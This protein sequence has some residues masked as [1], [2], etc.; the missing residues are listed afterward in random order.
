[1]FAVFDGILVTF[2][3]AG[4]GVLV[5]NVLVPKHGGFTVEMFHEMWVIVAIASFVCMCIA[6]FAI[7]KKDRPEYFGTGKAQKVGFKD[8]WDVLK[9]NR[10]IQMLVVSAST[11]KLAG[12]IRS[13]ATVTIIIFGIVCGNFALSGAVTAYTSI[14]TLLFLFLGVGVIAT[15]LGQKKAMEIGRA[16][17]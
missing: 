8:Y 12:T 10:A 5:S 1:M 2:L 16:H 4:L 14:P 9:N 3:F 15:K 7:S 11:D 17:V 13:N 6:V